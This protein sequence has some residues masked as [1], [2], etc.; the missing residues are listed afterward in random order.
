MLN[1][2]SQAVF[3]MVEKQILGTVLHDPPSMVGQ[4]FLDGIDCK[5]QNAKLFY[6]SL[7]H[8]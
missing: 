1:T 6:L 2:S 5:C 3:L 7:I 8:I 4:V